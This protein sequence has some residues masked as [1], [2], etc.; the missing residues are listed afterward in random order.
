M[1]QKFAA[2][3]KRIPREGEERRIVV[4]DRLAGKVS[5]QDVGYRPS[6]FGDKRSCSECDHYEIP[7]DST[8]VCRRVAGLVY[9]T[10]VCD[11]FAA[12]ER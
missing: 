6:V 4:V 5:K 12:N 1:R 8:S 3:L 9:G 7:G 11:M 2:L 10:D